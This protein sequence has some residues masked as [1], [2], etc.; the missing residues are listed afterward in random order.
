MSDSPRKA[1]YVP[2]PIYYVTAPPSIGNAYT[3]VAADVL[4]RWHRQ[5]GE[6][7]V[8]LTGTHEHGHN[9]VEAAEQNGVTPQEW[10]DRLVATE[11]QPVLDVI[12]ASNDDFI[13]T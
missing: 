2:T 3:T 5:M 7:V 8:F 4:A 10:T 11:W 13:R 6:T 12:D 9:V 1:F